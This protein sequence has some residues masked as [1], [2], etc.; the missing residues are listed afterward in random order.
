MPTSGR[1]TTAIAAP[2][3]VC[4]GVSGVYFAVSLKLRT[5]EPDDLQ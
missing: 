5:V 4:M 1:V 3:L 2:K